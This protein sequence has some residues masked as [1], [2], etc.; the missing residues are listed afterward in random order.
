MLLSLAGMQLLYPTPPLGCLPSAELSFLL[1][2]DISSARNTFLTSVWVTDPSDETPQLLPC[3]Y[4]SAVHG[5]PQAVS[6]LTHPSTYHMA[7]VC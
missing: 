1:S 4:P 7:G 2:S 5:L 3:T 6:V